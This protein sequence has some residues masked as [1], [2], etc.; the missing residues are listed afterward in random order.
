MSET[1]QCISPD[2]IIIG[3]DFGTTGMK[4]LALDLDGNAVAQVRLPNDLWTQGGVTE[5]N[6][7]Q[8]EGQA[9]DSTRALARQL[10]DA[11]RLQHWV[12]GGISATHHSAGRIDAD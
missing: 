6:L 12:A 5:L 1:L 3:W 9:F 11:K 2:S 10:R 7:M 8:L 4:A